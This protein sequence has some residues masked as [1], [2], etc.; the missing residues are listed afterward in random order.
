[1]ILC[2]ENKPISYSWAEVSTQIRKLASYIKSLKLKESS[3]ILIYGANEAEWIMADIAIM[4]TG[5]VSVP[6][7]PNITMENLQAVIQDSETSLA[8]L[9]RVECDDVLLDVES[10]VN[11]VLFS[12]RNAS[13]HSN[14]KVTSWQ[15]IQNGFEE[16]KVATKKK[17]QISR[18]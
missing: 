17:C 10:K 4:M 14:G 12:S 2:R 16:Y 11:V 13:K 15:D 5:H 7:Y 8:F 3:N 6:V 18:P 1:M 9:G